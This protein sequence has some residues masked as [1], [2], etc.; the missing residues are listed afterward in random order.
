MSAAIPPL[1]ATL[2]II[3]R[4]GQGDLEVCGATVGS[5][6]LGVFRMLSFAGFVA[7]ALMV[8]PAYAELESGPKVGADVMPFHVMDVTGKFKGTEV[9][10]RCKLGDAPVVAIFA[11]EINEKV[12]KA[13]KELNSQMN[14]NKE[15]KGFFVYVTDDMEKGQKELK[16]IAKKNE[17]KT[18][19]LTVFKG[20]E[21]PDGYKISEKAGVTVVAWKDSTVKVTKAYKP[22]AFC[23]QC[24]KGAVASFV[25]EH[26]K[27]E[28][29]GG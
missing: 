23:D 3:Q 28:K 29:T 6:V 20:K 2:R 9:C 4:R 7:T 13:C 1:F 25:K 24:C 22:G 5:A 11:R 27:T 19:P 8:S 26:V 21:G 18:L 10:Y 17:L 16:E 15:L 14:A 12:E